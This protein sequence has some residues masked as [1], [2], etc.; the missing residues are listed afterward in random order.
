MDGMHLPDWGPPSPH[1]RVFSVEAERAQWE[2]VEWRNVVAAVQVAESFG[3][4]RYVCLLIRAV[5]GFH[6]RRGNAGLLIR[7]NEMALAAAQR[8]GDLGLTAMAHNYLAGAHARAGQMAQ[9]RRHLADAIAL[10]RA[11]GDAAAVAFA[12]VN[13]MSVNMLG[14]QFTAAIAL[15]HGIDQPTP[16]D[17][18]SEPARLRIAIN[19]VL[20][21]RL[22]GECHIALGQ[23]RT[24]LR[25]L[26][27]AASLYGGLVDR[28]SYRF[29]VVLLHLGRVHARLRHRT[30][31]PLLL[32]R[33]LT[34]YE[35]R[36]NETG[37]VEALAELGILHLHAGDVRE[38]R[39]LNEQAVERAERG[40]TP[41]GRCLTLNRLGTTLLHLGD[42]A[43]AAPRHRE[44]L[45]IAQRAEFPY[46]EAVAHAGLAAALAT[47]DP[48]AA[49]WHAAE[50]ERMFAAMGAVGPYHLDD[51]IAD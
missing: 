8:L 27:Q 1:R 18:A 21:L 17:G 49:A 23:Y 45:A 12:L 20:V 22:L 35:Q 2:A 48:G 19:R 42:A 3:M 24:A 15:G 16:D 38:A 30:T 39:R 29:A 31:A 14:G 6:F 44:A 47:A 9:S 37:A 10:W 50:G 34:L 4:D 51:G 43:S 11:A 25:H 40:A 32:R 36:G 5:W 26:R 28:D 7:L 33:A 46:E 41:H 13:L